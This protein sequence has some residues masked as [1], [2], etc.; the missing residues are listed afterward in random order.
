VINPIPTGGKHYSTSL[1]D[2]AAVQF[3]A[4]QVRADTSK[5]M[6]VHGQKP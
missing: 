1:A 4:E 2:A 6:V 3:A 5:T